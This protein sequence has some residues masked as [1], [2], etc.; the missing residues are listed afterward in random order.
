MNSRHGRRLP[1]Y[2]PSTPSRTTRVTIPNNAPS[3]AKTSALPNRSSTNHS[4]ATTHSSASK[5]SPRNIR[6][7][8]TTKT[9]SSTSRPNKQR[10][11]NVEL[12]PT[13]KQIT[14]KTPII[15]EKELINAISAILSHNPIST[16]FSD[17]FKSAKNLNN[18]AISGIFNHLRSEFSARLDDIDISSI[19]KLIFQWGKFK[20]EILQIQSFIKFI[21]L[22]DLK[23]QYDLLPHWKYKELIKSHTNKCMDI[24]IDVWKS[25]VYPKSLYIL[26]DEIQNSIKKL[27]TN[28]N[29]NSIDEETHKLFELLSLLG[30]NLIEQIT[31]LF[32]N[33]Y[34]SLDSYISCSERLLYLI[35]KTKIL[36]SVF[37]LDILQPITIIPYINELVPILLE[38]RQ[39]E[40]LIEL[41][42]FILPEYISK[43]TSIVNQEM[44]K[45]VLPVDFFSLAAF[46]EFFSSVSMNDANVRNYVSTFISKGDSNF[47]QLFV[48][49]IFGHFDLPSNLKQLSPLI[50]LYADS[51]K[52]SNELVRGFLSKLLRKHSKTNEAEMKFAK[53][54]CTLFSNEQMRKVFT[55]LQDYTSYENFIII[56]T[57]LS[58][59]L[60]QNDQ[61]KVPLELEA[62]MMPQLTT[63]SKNFEKRKY[64]I[65]GTFSMLSVKAIYGDKNERLFTMSTL[66][67]SIIQM[68][69]RKE[70]N[71]KSTQ[72]HNDAVKMALIPLIK[73]GIIKKAGSSF[74]IQEKPPKEKKINVYIKAI[75]IRY[76][77]NQKLKQS[78]DHSMSIQSVIA[79]LMKANRKML[80]S[81]LIA[82]VEAELSPNFNIRNGDIPKVIE[83]MIEGEYIEKYKGDTRFIVYI[84]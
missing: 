34:N 71:F 16:S 20:L 70:T 30:Y 57:A 40:A 68:I 17:L 73:G 52:L 69:L 49:V 56:N 46:L 82:Q 42:N 27:T 32:L 33:E 11:T 84:P 61:A 53:F 21:G 48:A 65:S 55:M 10:N 4:F 50:P 47:P 60:I 79:K 28:P 37:P 35:N 2:T 38:K 25:E 54:L 83:H 74:V 45:V 41:K 62:K 6:V 81:D 64:R 3:F 23:L 66:Q 22:N 18:Q 24:G 78:H 80:E 77:E 8:T 26:H 31:E 9:M 13:S 58:M 72:A 67:Y 12:S 59:P 14:A 7:G 36:T 29:Q 19:Q 75:D 43:Y 1:T 44:K 51:E 76:D 5:P 39:K 63:Y 15:P